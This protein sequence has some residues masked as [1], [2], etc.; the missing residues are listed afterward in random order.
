MKSRYFMN[1]N[2][3]QYLKLIFRD[4]EANEMKLTDNDKAELERQFQ[5]ALKTDILQKEDAISI[6]EIL[7]NA[8]RRRQE[9]MEKEYPWLKVSDIVQ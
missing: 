2:C 1:I 8:V 6:L 9:E 7:A 4:N 3:F 5:G